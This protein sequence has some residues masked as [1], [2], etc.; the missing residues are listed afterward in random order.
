MPFLFRYSS[1]QHL[2]NVTDTAA[3]IDGSKQKSK[4]PHGATGQLARSARYG[5]AA[6]PH[7]LCYRQRVTIYTQMQ[8]M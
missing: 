1:I 2:D 3:S 5:S 8:I 4:L 7:T 6:S